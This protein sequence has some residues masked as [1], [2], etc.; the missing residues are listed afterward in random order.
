MQRYV[1]LRLLDGR[2]GVGVLGAGGSRTESLGMTSQQA[3]AGL[4]FGNVL[5]IRG[6]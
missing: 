6:C 4:I 2:G 5:I 3:E 1:L